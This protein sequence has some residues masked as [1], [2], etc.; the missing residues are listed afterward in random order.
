MKLVFSHLIEDSGDWTLSKNQNYARM[1]E[2]GPNR[3]ARKIPKMKLI[4]QCLHDSDM[5][6][7][8]L[9]SSKRLNQSLI[10][11]ARILVSFKD[12]DLSP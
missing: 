1:A 7:L 3:E 2:T 5:S 8:S 4:T 6:C 11:L 12:R 9:Q 10:V